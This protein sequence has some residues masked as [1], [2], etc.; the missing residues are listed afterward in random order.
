VILNVKYNPLVMDSE[1]N[2]IDTETKPV[3]DALNAYLQTLAYGSGTANKTKMFD[4]IQ[5]AEGVVDVWT[6][7]SNWL[8]VSTD[9][10]SSFIVVTTQDLMSYG[11][12]FKF[13]SDDDIVINYIANV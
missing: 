9:G 5:S 3:N 13:N 2:L 7:T 1:G 6:E 8:Y 10:D 12:S 11:G 4:T